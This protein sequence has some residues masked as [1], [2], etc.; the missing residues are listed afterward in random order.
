MA[1][2]PATGPVLLIG[3]G[4]DPAAG[5]RLYGEVLAA[6]DAARPQVGCVV[7]DEGD[8]TEQFARWAGALSTAGP[9]D[10]VPVLVPEGGAFDVAALGDADAV[11]VCGGL[12]P[13][14]AAALAPARQ[15]LREWLAQRHRPYAGFSAGAAV[16]ASRAVVGGWL[17]GGIP[18]C[19]EDAGEDLEQVSVVD[20]LGLVPFGVDV[21][22]AQ[23]GT[24]P[25]LLSALADLPGGMGVGLDENTLLTV[26]GSTARVSGTGHAW[27]VTSDADGARVRALRQG[28][29]FT[30][31][32][33][34]L[35]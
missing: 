17:V 8:G 6:C 18:V 2:D 27:L 25:R 29:E 30:L 7:L 13:A 19:P 10:P 5:R 3:G 16:A 12:T 1:S 26:A 28:A 31:Q 35:T 20:G 24:L 21:H 22:C 33:A 4:W 23:W 9:C 11:L 34:L 14:Y 32:Q 15:Q